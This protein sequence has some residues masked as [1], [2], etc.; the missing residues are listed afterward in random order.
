[1]P[2]ICSRATRAALQKYARAHC[3]DW[4]SCSSRLLAR[5]TMPS[6][7]IRSRG[8]AARQ[9]P[10]PTQAWLHYS[11]DCRLGSS[12]TQEADRAHEGEASDPVCSVFSGTALAL[13][14]VFG[15][16]A[17]TGRTKSSTHSVRNGGGATRAKGMGNVEP[18]ISTS[19]AS[20]EEQTSCVQPSE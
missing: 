5:S 3:W 4:K 1:M 19:P 11:R 17:A 15:V 7:P 2:P 6:A 9:R 10:D 13:E 16:A 20:P 12:L 14:V 8:S 18:V